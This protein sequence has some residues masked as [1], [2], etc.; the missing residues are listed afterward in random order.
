[1]VAHQ[2]EGQQID[3]EVGGQSFDLGLDPLFPVVEV[4]ACQRI[5]PKQEATS[6][7]PRNAVNCSDFAR[8]KYF[9]PSQSRHGIA[10]PQLPVPRLGHLT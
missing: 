4:L 8:M 10:S 9:C 3:P 6:S 7:H 5:I 2:A 1:M